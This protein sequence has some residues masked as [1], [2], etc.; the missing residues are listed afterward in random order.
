M[1]GNNKSKIQNQHNN[2]ILIVFPVSDFLFLNTSISKID[3]IPIGIETILLLVYILFFFYQYFKKID[4][5]YIYN[6]P[7]FWVAVGILLYLGGSFFFNILAN[8]LSNTEM[9]KYYY[10]TYITEIIK[11][12]LLALAMLI[13]VFQPK[14]TTVV[15][16]IPYLDMTS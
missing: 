10:V 11:N 3:T 4:N 9:M 5:R 16:P 13:Y 7:C 15:K 1:A 2:S 8:H 6:E 12:L 14:K